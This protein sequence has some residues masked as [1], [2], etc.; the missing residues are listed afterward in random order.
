[1]KKLLVIDKLILLL[2][3]LLVLVA[4]KTVNPSKTIPETQ[5]T[6]ETKTSN[7]LKVGDK[8]IHLE[9]GSLRNL[10]TFKGNISDFVLKLFSSDFTLKNGKPVFD[11][12]VIS[13]VI[14]DLYVNNSSRLV[15]TSYEKV[16]YKEIS[17][18]SFQALDIAVNYNL[19]NEKGIKRRIT[20]GKL[21]VSSTDSIYQFKF[22]G[23]DNKGKEVIFYYKGKLLKVKGVKL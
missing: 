11:D 23:T 13:G 2:L 5:T 15:S 16:S 21:K 10:G 22:T 7:F 17:G 18:N 19:I 8:D 3:S 14:V 9:S 20:N 6:S 4:C 1:M 12:T